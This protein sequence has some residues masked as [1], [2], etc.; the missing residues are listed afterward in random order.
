MYFNVQKKDDTTH[1]VSGKEVTKETYIQLSKDA[2]EYNHDLFFQ[3]LEKD[4]DLKHT[5]IKKFIDTLAL[6]TQIVIK[7]SKMLYLHGY[8][9]YT[10]LDEYL[11]KNPA[12]DFVNILETGTARG[13]SSVCMAKALHDNKRDGKIYTVDV[14]PNNQ[15]M[16]W[17]CVE[18]FTGPKTRPQLLSKW[19]Y[20][21]EYIEFVQ[22]DS[23][24]ILDDLHEKFFVPRIH[25][26]FLDA[27][28]TY[29]YLKHEMD[30]VKDR[31]EIGDV[32]IC[33]DYTTY[34]SGRPQYP[35][36]IRAVDEFVQES[37][38]DKKM[39]IGDDGDKERGY[40]HLVN[41]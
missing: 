41:K 15:S 31:Q 23:K 28:H 33:D 17:N 36:I 1:I 5:T 19:D 18:D 10:A 38:Y 11:K 14:L 4:F 39:Y 29:S 40:V 32:I 24:K 25:F 26:S 22:G 21:L 8:L 6:S 34:H 7:E 16:F 37:K 12:I 13:F 35:G 9:L 30:W 27:Q 20:L 2:S 3:D